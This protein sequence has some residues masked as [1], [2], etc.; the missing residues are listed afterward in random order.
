MGKRK[1]DWN[2]LYEK[3]SQAIKQWRAANPQAT[4]VEIETKVNE[5]MARVRAKL[6][7]DLIHESAS[8]EWRDREK[9]DRP[10]CP[11]CETAL[12]SNGMQKRGLVTDHG[13]VVE[14]HR[15]HGR[16]PKCGTTVFPPG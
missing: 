4:F 8:T 6:M 14:L 1:R 7:E 3:A 12:S 2:A 15:S 10:K 5:E 11:V 13:Q 16:C 9:A